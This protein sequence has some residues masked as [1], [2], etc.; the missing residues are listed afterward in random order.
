MSLFLTRIIPHKS[1]DLSSPPIFQQDGRDSLTLRF[2]PI[3]V[4]W[5]TRS[6]ASGPVSRRWRAERPRGGWAVPPRHP[7]PGGAGRPPAS[8]ARPLPSELEER[9]KQ[10]RERATLSAEF[11]SC[12]DIGPSAGYRSHGA[13]SA[14]HSSWQAK[15]TKKISWI[16]TVLALICPLVYFKGQL[17]HEQIS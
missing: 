11:F 16:S 1:W 15:W 14:K 4:A 2:R 9:E 13:W 10:W 12:P 5:R 3:P 8:H 7:A 6:P 17:F